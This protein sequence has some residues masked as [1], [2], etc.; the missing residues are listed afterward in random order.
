MKDSYEAAIDEARKITKDE[1]KV[2]GVSSSQLDRA[3]RLT[4]R[5]MDLHEQVTRTCSNGITL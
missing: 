3:V 2:E 5:R 4:A 1:L